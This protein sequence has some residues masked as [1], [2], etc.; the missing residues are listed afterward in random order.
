MHVFSLKYGH[1]G[2]VMCVSATPSELLH[3]HAL[4]LW[5]NL[6][7]T[8]LYLCA[9]AR[10]HILSLITRVEY[11]AAI[12][13]AEQHNDPTSTQLISFEFCLQVVWILRAFELGVP[14]QSLQP[15]CWVTEKQGKQGAGQD[16]RRENKLFR[17]SLQRVAIY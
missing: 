7:A 11:V 1:N 3:L 8:V 9:Q 16:N 10:A 5:G 12:C 6:G 2:S 15:P 17:F 14:A 4:H 13:Y